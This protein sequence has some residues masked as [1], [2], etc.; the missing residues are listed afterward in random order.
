MGKREYLIFLGLVFELVAL[1]VS[2][3]Y[4][5]YYVDQQM[6]WSGIGV[7]CGA[8]LALVIWVIHLMQAFKNLR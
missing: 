1:V 7:A 3:V 5:G 8:V 6:G 2:L 4:A